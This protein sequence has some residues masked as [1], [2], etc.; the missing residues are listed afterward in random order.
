MRSS[1]TKESEL[2]L[3][4]QHAQR[5]ILQLKHHIQEAADDDERVEADNYD[6]PADSSPA[7]PS[8]I[9]DEETSDVPTRSTALRSSRRRGKLSKDGDALHKISAA[10]FAK[11]QKE[12]QV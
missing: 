9:E 2:A 4:L 10:E 3:R 6:A 8:S 7:S 11:M 1:T 5:Q 12:I